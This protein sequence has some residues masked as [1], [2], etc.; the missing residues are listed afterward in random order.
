MWWPIVLWCCSCIGGISYDDCADDYEKSLLRRIREQSKNCKNNEMSTEED[1]ER[2]EYY[3]ASGGS[4]LDK[5]LYRRLRQ[6]ANGQPKA[7][8]L[9]PN[10]YMVPGDP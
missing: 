3:G 5:F 1:E 4:N 8:R 2:E 9:T 10:I 7:R 6:D